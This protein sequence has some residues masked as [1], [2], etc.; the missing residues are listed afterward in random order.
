[1]KTRK[2][3]IHEI[4]VHEH[5]REFRVIVPGYCREAERIHIDTSEY[6]PGEKRCDYAILIA[7]LCQQFFFYVELKG[8]HTLEAAKQLLETAR[9]NKKQHTGY[10]H[11]EAWIVDGG[12]FI[13][14]TQYQCIQRNLKE[15]GFVL[16]R[17]TKKQE[18]DLRGELHCRNQTCNSKNNN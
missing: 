3:R 13:A 8:N 5:N 15:L 14:T 16:R 2:E 11:K 12:R 1:M 10:C 6:K 4:V 17:T 18:R 7:P 9:N